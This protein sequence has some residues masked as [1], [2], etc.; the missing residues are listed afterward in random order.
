MSLA[1]VS[2]CVILRASHCHK[3]STRNKPFCTGVAARGHS[4]CKHDSLAGRTVGR[5]HFRPLAASTYTVDAANV[6]E[7][8]SMKVGF[9]GLGIMG[10]AMVRMQCT[11]A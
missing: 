6:S 11:A 9:V 5:Q 1:S 4:V 2:T 10:C 7:K 8:P 3:Q